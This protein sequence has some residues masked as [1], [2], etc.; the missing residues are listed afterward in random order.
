MGVAFKYKQDKAII[1]KNKRLNLTE[2]QGLW[3]CGGTWGNH[4]SSGLVL[5][6]IA[7]KK[8]SCNSLS[9]IPDQRCKTIC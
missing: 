6:K 3:Q 5:K 4:E 2:E 8:F 7:A 1:I 9:V